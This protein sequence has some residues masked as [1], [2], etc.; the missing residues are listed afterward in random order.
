MLQNCSKSTPPQH[1]N[2]TSMNVSG[3]SRQ[4]PDCR[5]KTTATST[6]AKVLHLRYF[7]TVFCTI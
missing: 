1:M 5:C 2:I 4:S 7:Q 3:T 6:T